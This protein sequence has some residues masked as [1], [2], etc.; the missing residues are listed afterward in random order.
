MKS[1]PGRVSPFWNDRREMT[2]RKSEFLLFE[3]M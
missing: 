1:A 2:K 3:E